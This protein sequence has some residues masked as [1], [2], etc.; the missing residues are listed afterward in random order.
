MRRATRV[1][2]SVAAAVAMLA[3]LVTAVGWR[4]LLTELR[5]ANTEWVLAAATLSAVSLLCWA[6]EV[7]QLFRSAGGEAS[8]LGIRAVYFAGVFLKIVVPGGHVG[9]VGIVAYVL[10]RY[11]GESFEQSLVAVSAGEFLNNVAS[12]T[13]AAVGIV[14]LLVATSAPASFLRAGAVAVVGLVAGLV[15]A[16][17]VLVRFDGAE[18]SLAWLAAAVRKTVGRFS[19]RIHD[20]LAEDRVAQRLETL[21]DTLDAVRADRRTLVFTIVVAHV[22]W[23]CYAIPLY[24]SLQAVDAG[25]AFPVAL[26]VVPVAGLASVV[27]TPGGLGTVDTAT[28][29]A[30]VL[31]TSVDPALAGAATF[32]FRAATF[33]LTVVVTG[34]ATAG[35]M[36]TGRLDPFDAVRS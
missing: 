24:C 22:G 13:L 32:L 4:S 15:A 26:F 6:E 14:Y 31:L 19:E 5:A 28:A 30:L 9:G 36:A 20:A 7:V 17:V 2:L 21:G 33:G 10:G 34:L 27:G 16:Y 25:V 1:V 35:L 23:L 18:R 11:T 29:G 8:G 3:L 12:A